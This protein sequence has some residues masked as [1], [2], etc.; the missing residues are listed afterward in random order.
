MVST[1]QMR[2]WLRAKDLSPDS[3]IG[4]LDAEDWNIS[5]IPEYEL[6]YFDNTRDTCFKVRVTEEVRNN[7]KI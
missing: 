6:V 5:K 4:E 2:A 7:L 3:P 1:D